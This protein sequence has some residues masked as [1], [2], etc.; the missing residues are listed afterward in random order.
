VFCRCSLPW[1]PDPHPPSGA[2]AQTWTLSSSGLQAGVLPR[3][4]LETADL[5][6][7]TADLFAVGTRSVPAAAAFPPQP[8]APAPSTDA[9]RS[10][11]VPPAMSKAIKAPTVIQPGQWMCGHR[12]DR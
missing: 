12:R 10:E 1:T 8:C 2:A 5:L 6:A 11:P 9:R 4:L 3:T 7:S